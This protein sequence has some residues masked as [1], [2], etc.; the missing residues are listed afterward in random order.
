MTVR[1]ENYVSVLD[2]GT[3]AEKT[4][5]TVPNGPGMQIFSPDGKYGYVCCARRKHARGGQPAQLTAMNGP[6]R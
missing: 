6:C 2:G 4:R 1:G 3:H 5:I